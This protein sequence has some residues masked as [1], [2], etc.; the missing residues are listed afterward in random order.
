M[1]RGHPT[2]P[3]RTLSAHFNTLSA[4]SELLLFLFRYARGRA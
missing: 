4:A 3:S 1:P 2:E